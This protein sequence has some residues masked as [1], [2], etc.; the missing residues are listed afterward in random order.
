MKMD[1]M[2]NLGTTNSVVMDNLETSVNVDGFKL[3]DGRQINTISLK[4]ACNNFT[5][6]AITILKVLACYEKV[7][8]LQKITYTDTKEAIYVLNILNTTKTGI[9]FDTFKKLGIN[10]TNLR[11]GFTS[12]YKKVYLPN[13][14]LRD[15]NK[16]GPD[17]GAQIC[18]YLLSLIHLFN[19]LTIKPVSLNYE[20]ALDTVTVETSF[21]E[22][23]DKY[24]YDFPDEKNITFTELPV[25]D[26][27]NITFFRTAYSVIPTNCVAYNGTF[28]LMKFNNKK[29]EE[30][31]DIIY[32]YGAK[33]M[34]PNF[35][36]VHISS[37]YNIV[38][39]NNLLNVMDL[40]SDS[41]FSLIAN[42]YSGVTTIM[43][44]KNLGLSKD[45]D[46]S[47]IG[48]DEENCTEIIKNITSKFL[49]IGISESFNISEASKLLGIKLKSEGL[50]DTSTIKSQYDD[51][52]YAQ[53][54]YKQVQDYYDN[55]D[56]KELS[57]IV[58]AFAK[59]DTYSM[60]FYGESGT[61]KSTA[62][63]V[64]PYRC[65]MPYISINF[66][67]NIEESD[68]IGTMIPNVFKKGPEDPEF[69]WQDGILTRAVRAGY[70]AVC[71]EI[72]F[73]RPGILG[74]LNSLLDEN[75]QIELP[76]GEIV[77][78][79]KNFRLIAT[80]NIA[81]EGTQRLNKA[82][83]NRFELVYEF[84]DLPREELINIIID[85]TK[86][87]DRSKIEKILNV[88]D[89]IKKYSKEQNLGVVIS[90]RQLLSLFR[91]GKYFKNAQSAVKAILVNGAF[92]EDGEYKINF[93]ETILKA[94]DLKFKI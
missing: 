45:V 71:E 20:P 34:N 91:Q 25:E 48:Y 29:S 64:I 73:A 27:E 12:D 56:L 42:N 17:A 68:L 9:I 4:S 26:L 8:W 82:F 54:L 36:R 2:Y 28:S 85:R 41:I 18:M 44:N 69:V 19:G 92:I 10:L 83:I 23:I 53:E 32:N 31:T 49:E 52:P 76:T 16:F 72:N 50:F 89:A 59:G 38:I 63:R 5:F 86:Y 75:R 78:A 94:F 51:D 70:T 62:A 15:I 57:S 11:L 61:G 30:C 67:T 39:V 80:C 55:F 47:I 37:V 60:I 13:K 7:Y 40:D 74:K 22:N 3:T 21:Y 87:S 65:G 90:L 33:A 88:Y 1:L 81:Y 84:E 66:S 93:V 77:K 58:K 43:F 79:H 24:I 6:K 46:Y 14:L 35:I